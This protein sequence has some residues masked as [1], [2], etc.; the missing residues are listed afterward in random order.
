[1][2]A[3]RA[4]R[5]GKTRDQLRELLAQEYERRGI[6]GVRVRNHRGG[7]ILAAE[8]DPLA[9]A[10]SAFAAVRMMKSLGYKPDTA[11]EVWATAGS[12]LGQPPDR[13]ELRDQ[14]NRLA[15]KDRGGTQSRRG[16]LAPGGL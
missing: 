13:A 4:Q 1:M 15:R 16:L 12:R 9:R 3:V 11:G 14:V 7:G 10:R 2:D 6:E 5:Q 8:E